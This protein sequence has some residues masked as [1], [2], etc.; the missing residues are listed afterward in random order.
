M[1]RIFLL[2]VVASGCA[3]E[4]SLPSASIPVAV[5]CVPQDAPTF[6][7]LRSNA[8][9]KALDDRRIVLALAEERLSLLGYSKRAEAVINACR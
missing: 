9:L 3:T 8:E 6:P 4:P 2:C 1:R 5:S 7:P